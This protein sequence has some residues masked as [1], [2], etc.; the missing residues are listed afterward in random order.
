MTAVI[1]PGGEQQARSTIEAVEAQ[2]RGVE[3]IAAV[4]ETDSPLAQVQ[5]GWVWLLDAGVVPDR[6]ALERLLASTKGVSPVPALLASRVVRA[7][8]ALDSSSIPIAEVH[9]PQR[10]LA[11]LEQRVVSLRAARSGSLLVASSALER[12]APGSA[13]AVA[14]RALEW[15][16]RMLRRELGVLVP[17]SVVVRPPDAERQPPAAVR[18]SVALSLLG[19]LESRERLW[20]AA[21]L[22]ERAMARFRRSR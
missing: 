6:S 15:S 3:R 7:D 17:G 22:G 10:V 16:A 5:P 21:H 19:A 12:D 1:L 13:A 11:A 18:V 4:G 20:F 2:S 8:G 14:D 9:Q